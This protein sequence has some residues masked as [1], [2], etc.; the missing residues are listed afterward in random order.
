MI[1]LIHGDVVFTDI[2]HT[3]PD[4]FNCE[5]SELYDLVYVGY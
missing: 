2:L 3:Q 5:P 4:Q 1:L